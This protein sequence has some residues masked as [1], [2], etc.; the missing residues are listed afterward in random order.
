MYHFQETGLSLKKGNQKKKRPQ[1]RSK[2]NRILKNLK[3]NIGSIIVAELFSRSI[4][5]LSD[6]YSEYQEEQE[7][8][9]K[10]QERQEK[11][12]DAWGAERERLQREQ[13]GSNSRDHDVDRG[14]SGG[15]A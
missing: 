12:R 2:N 7:R 10:E 13:G 11:E 4:D 14:R 6:K 3:G 5:F 15:L 8:L 1:K 9:R